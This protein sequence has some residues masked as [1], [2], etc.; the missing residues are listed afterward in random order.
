MKVI[1][2]TVVIPLKKYKK[3]WVQPRRYYI[4]TAGLDLS[5]VRKIVVTKVNKYLANA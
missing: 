5:F 1:L 3:L 2:N 4:I